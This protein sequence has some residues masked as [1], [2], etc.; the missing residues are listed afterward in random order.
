LEGPSGSHAVALTAR[1][2]IVS[3]DQH[4]RGA[5]PSVCLI[6]LASILTIAIGEALTLGWLEVQ[7]A[8]ENRPE[9]EIVFFHSSGIEHFRQVVGLSLQRLS[10]PGDADPDAASRW[11][12]SPS[13]LAGQ[14]KPLVTKL[15]LREIVNVPE[16]W[17]S[18]HGR[19]CC[20]AAASTLVLTDSLA[21]S[22]RPLQPGMLVF[23]VN[24]TCVPTGALTEVGLQ[25]PDDPDHHDVTLTMTV[26]RRSASHR[27]IR[28]L[29]MPT[30]VASDLLASLGSRA[31]R[32]EGAA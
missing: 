28:N 27:I 8:A 4:R 20:R 24:V 19:S 30:A 1:S 10:G 3:R 7:Y 11:L 17:T 21:E 5:F 15:S 2:L 22:E 31:R 18:D 32:W 6:P 13:Y 25:L 16:A 23:G 14:V 9:A 29:A 12:S 26:A